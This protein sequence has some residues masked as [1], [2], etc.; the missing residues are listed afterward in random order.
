[1]SAAVRPNSLPNFRR[2]AR[3]IVGLAGPR[4]SLALAAHTVSGGL[5]WLALLLLAA[6]LRAGGLGVP[7]IVPLPPAWPALALG[8]ALAAFAAVKLIQLG[9]RLAGQV[10]A[11]ES[12]AAFT[13]ALRRRHYRAVL[14]SDWLFF[15]RQRASDVT[16]VQLEEITWAGQGARQLLQFSGLALLAAVQVVIAAR[17]APGFT[18]ALLIAAGG[19]LGA[20]RFW[21]R[22]DA[23]PVAAAPAQRASLAAAITDQLAGM[24][25]ARSYGCTESHRARFDAALATLDAGSSRT[26]KRWAIRRFAAEGGAFLLVAVFVS[27]ALAGQPLGTGTVLLLAFIFTRLLGLA[28][29]LQSAWQ[30]F[31]RGLPSWLAVEEQ[32]ARFRA[33][34]EPAGDVLPAPAELTREVRFERVSFRY[35]PELAPALQAIDLVLPARQVTALCGPSGAGKST[36]ADVA[37]GLLRPQAGAVL[38]DG[39]PLEGARLAGWRRRVGYVPQDPFLF[40]DTIRNNLLWAQPAASPAEL[41]AALAAAAAADFVA[42]LPDGLD[43]VVGDRGQRLSGGERQRLALARALLRRPTLLVL[44]EATSALDAENERLVQES[45]ER[46]RGETTVLLIAHRL[47]TLRAADRIVVLA[48]GRIAESGTWEE[49]D[50]GDGAFR[51]LLAAAARS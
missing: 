19:L 21:Q 23:D 33:A 34:A 50:A 44:D 41:H 27:A 15:S 37:L 4:F 12:A 32:R 18:L 40:H 9:V 47:S 45:V 25:L 2:Y 11:Q 49:L 35:A 5:E 30:H 20:L 43:T 38:L 6:V 36:L 1:V 16:Q 26:E 24:K 42:A 48:G 29:Q 7:V 8:T 31:A 14:D 17:L 13:T 39:L 46:L 22:R 28:L 3:E 10:L 51:A